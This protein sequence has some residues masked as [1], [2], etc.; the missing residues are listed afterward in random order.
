MQAF[1]FYSATD[2]HS[3]TPVL[4]LCMGFMDRAILT[5]SPFPHTSSLSLHN[6]LPAPS[7]V[8]VS[9]HPYL[10]MHKFIFLMLSF[11]KLTMVL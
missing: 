8:A 1:T 9:P 10:F 6:P 7:L 5:G 2:Y 4:E 3:V 11:R